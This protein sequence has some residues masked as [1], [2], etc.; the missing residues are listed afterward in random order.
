M[1]LPDDTLQR[2]FDHDLPED[3]AEQVAAALAGSADDQARL[4]A[5]GRIGDLVRLGAEEATPALDANALFA[6]IEAGRAAQ[7]HPRLRVIEGQRKRRTAVGVGVAL[8]LAAAVTLVFLLQPP[9][10]DPSIARHPFDTHREVLVEN[11]Q[12]HPPG[13]S[14]VESVDFGSNTGTVF[15]VAGSEGQPLAVVWIDEGSQ[16]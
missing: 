3:E 5:L 12:V 16:P 6:R 10:D 13:G 4:A 11:V 9:V 14:E 8:A 1:S 15:H 2:Y 7:P